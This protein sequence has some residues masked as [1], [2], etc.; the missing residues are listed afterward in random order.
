MEFFKRTYIIETNYKGKT[1]KEKKILTSTLNYWLKNA[2]LDERDKHVVNITFK[3]ATKS[4][5]IMT[6]YSSYNLVDGYQ[7]KITLVENKK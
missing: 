3:Y 2:S 1:K 5:V 7:I 4:E 6:S